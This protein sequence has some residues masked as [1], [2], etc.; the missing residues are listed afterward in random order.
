M[1][2]FRG[3]MKSTEKHNNPLLLFFPSR[4]FSERCD[5]TGVTVVTDD[6]LWDMGEGVFS[7]TRQRSKSFEPSQCRPSLIV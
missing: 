7:E 3:A 4:L 1:L 6:A 2:A 5:V